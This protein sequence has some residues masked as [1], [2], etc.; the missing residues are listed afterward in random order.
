M[1]QVR[2]STGRLPGLWPE[3]SCH[4]LPSH[5]ISLGEP[6][7]SNPLQSRGVLPE[8]SHFVSFVMDFDFFFFFFE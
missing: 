7:V 3:N 6:P 4:L 5:V 1:S 8:N 2:G